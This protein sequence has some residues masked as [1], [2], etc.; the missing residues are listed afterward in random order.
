YGLLTQTPGGFSSLFEHTASDPPARP[1]VYGQHYVYRVQSVATLE[2]SAEFSNA[3]EG[4]RQLPAVE[5]FYV[6]DRVF[7]DRVRLI[8]LYYDNA[9]QVRLRRDGAEIATVDINANVCTYDDDPG[10]FADHEYTAHA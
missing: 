4:Y 2:T 6:S 3:D 5:E 10:D 7:E 9:S 8:G 1:C